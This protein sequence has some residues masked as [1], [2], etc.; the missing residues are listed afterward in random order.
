MTVLIGGPTLPN[1]GLESNHRR[2]HAV[3]QPLPVVRLQSLGGNRRAYEQA[4]R[5]GAQAPGALGQDL[6]RVMQVHG[7]DRDLRRDREP[8]RRVLERQ[9]LT[10]A[11]TRS[12][13]ENED[14]RPA[15]N[16]AR[17]LVVR[18]KRALA[19][20]PID[21]DVSHREHRASQER[22]PKQLPFCDE[23]HRPWERGEQCPDVEHRGMIGDVDDGLIFGD[24]LESFGD[25]RRSRCFENVPRPVDTPPVIDAAALALYAQQCRDDDAGCMNDCRDDEDY[26]IPAGSDTHAK[27]SYPAGSLTG[28]L[29]SRSRSPPRRPPAPRRQ[30][31]MR[32]S[33]NPVLARN[34]DAL[35]SPNVGGMV[36]NS[37]NSSPLATAAIASTFSQQGMRSR[38]ISIPTPDAAARCCASGTSPS[39]MSIIAVAPASANHWPASMR[40]SGH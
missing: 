13:G 36:S 12:F 11:A 19:R 18:L 21:G 29:C 17:R 7:E 30:E 28:V 8:E 5:T 27:W 4:D 10:R 26:V 16:P 22:D 20:R 40:G 39:E 38:L 6:E 37:S 1:L 31:P 3:A 24:Q 35:E 32:L 33:C 14:R 2:A 9:Q 23:A 34:A 15:L 25:D